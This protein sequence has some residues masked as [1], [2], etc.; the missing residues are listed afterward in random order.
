M[1]QDQPSHADKPDSSAPPPREIAVDAVSVRRGS[2]PQVVSIIGQPIEMP[3]GQ[4]ELGLGDYA[5]A[6]TT[7]E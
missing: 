1:N 5:R 3:L 7:L 4:V 6:H 2:G